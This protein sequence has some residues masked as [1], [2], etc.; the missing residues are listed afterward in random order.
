MKPAAQKTIFTIL[1]SLSLF[2]IGYLTWP[3]IFMWILPVV[4]DVKY[5]E[6]CFGSMFD[7][8]LLFGLTLALIP[9]SAILIWKFGHIIKSPQ[10]IS[11]VCIIVIA[12]VT[13]IGI[14][15]TIVKSTARNMKP[16]TVIDYSDPSFPVTQSIEKG[17]PVNTLHFETFAL[18]G[19]IAGSIISFFALRQKRADIHH[20][21]TII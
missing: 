12:I 19:L 21:P 18:G 1:V 13:A 8:N 15:R 2:F 6:S 20:D 11:T 10:R 17:I 7:N 5:F 4:G 3:S 9:V 16:I 14:R